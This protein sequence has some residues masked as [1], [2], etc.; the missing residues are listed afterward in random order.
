MCILCGGQC[1]GVV[2]L[3]ISLGLPFVAIYFMRLRG[4][5]T[6]LKNSILRR[7]TPGAGRQAGA[8]TWEDCG[9][10]LSAGPHKLSPIISPVRLDQSLELS[11]AAAPKQ[12]AKS[13]AGGPEGVKGWLLLLCVNLMILIPAF[14]LYQTNCIV[15]ILFLPQ[16]RILLSI[17]SRNYYYFN[18][19]MIFIM[20]FVAVYSFS[21]GWRLWSIKEG[22]IRSAKNFLIVQLSLTLVTLTFQHIMT[23]SSAGIGYFSDQI[24]VQALT[25]ILYFSVWYTYLVKSRRV[26]NTYGLVKKN[27]VTVC[28]SLITYPEAAKKLHC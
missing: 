9:E 8:T 16:Y 1:G 21:S 14:S 19:A 12:L 10:L 23:S 17:W 2:D 20:L 24:V 7:P 22:A 13:T 5:L 28:G 6:R 18:I 26:F 11:I 15:D 25:S 3:L 27:D 4:F